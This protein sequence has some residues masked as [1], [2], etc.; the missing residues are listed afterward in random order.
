[1][2]S[3]MKESLANIEYDKKISILTSICGAS[4]TLNNM[5]I[6]K[7]HNNTE[8]LYIKQFTKE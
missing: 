8:P 4:N 6:T 2:Y 1:M 5:N 7:V 3:R